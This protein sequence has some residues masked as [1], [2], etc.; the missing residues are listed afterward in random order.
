VTWVDSLHAGQNLVG[1]LKPDLVILGERLVDGEALPLVEHLQGEYPALPLILFSSGASDLQPGDLLRQ[2]LAAILVAPLRPDEVLTSVARALRHQRALQAWAQAKARQ[3][4]RSL[5][6]RVDELET[7]S[8]FGKSVSASL[9]LDA[10]LSAAVEA[11]VELTSAEEGS[12]LLLDSDSGELYMRASRNFQDEFARTFRLPV[13]DTLAGQVIQTGEPILLDEKTPQKIKTAYLVHTLIY[14]PL[15][16]PGRVIGV[17]GVDNRQSDRAFED[18]HITLLTAIADYA[19]VAIEN[20]RLYAISEIERGKLETILTQI[21]DSVVVIDPQGQLILVNR[22]A[23]EAFGL[24]PENWAGRAALE[25]IEHEDLRQALQTSDPRP[26]RLEIE[27]QNGRCYNVQLSSIPQVGQAVTMQDISHFRELDRIKS[28]FVNTVSHDLRSP[29]T[30]I[31]GYVEL[32]ERSG[33]VNERQQEF[34]RRVQISVKNITELINDLLDL[35]RIEAGLDLEREQVPVPVLLNYAV[36]GLRQ[37]LNKKGLSLDVDVQADLPRLLGNPIRLRQLFDN[38]LENAIKYTPRGGQIAV[39]ARAE[40]D[41][42]I[43]Q[44]QDNGIGIPLKEQPYIFDKMY[45]ASNVDA[46][47]EGTGLGLSIVRSIV[48]SHFGRI[49]VDSAPGKGSNF[50]VVLPIVG[51]GGKQGGR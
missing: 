34:I 40:E 36:D 25:V 35:G 41:Q 15:R 30:A 27:L 10:V 44:V 11:A 7:L 24:D 17:L 43:L 19:A 49:W 8:R 6:R 26:Y 39:R 5:R 32:I 45:R 1:E 16:L 33:E 31:L 28:D 4:T 12:L 13:K 48:E 23:Q 42:M 38:L 3:T 18:H 46:D 51:S 2:G 14:V 21:E 20:A 37:R 22:S 50:T 47:A 29:L 9:D